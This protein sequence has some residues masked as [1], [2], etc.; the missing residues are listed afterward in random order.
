[1]AILSVIVPIFNASQFLKESLDSVLNQNVQ[2]LEV[3]CVND[4]S[5]D[6][7]LEILKGYK[8]KRIKIF[9][10]E[11]KGP[12]AT[13]NRG[14]KEA[15]GEYVAFFD[16][17]DIVTPVMYEK[18][19]DIAIKE[20]L[21]IVMCGFQYF[22]HKVVRIP[23][24]K[25]N[26]VVDPITFLSKNKKIHTTSDLCF[27]WRFIFKKSFLLNNNLQFIESIKYGED[28]VFNLRAIMKTKR[29]FL[30]PEPLYLYRVDNPNSI[31]SK[32]YKPNMES[33][34][35][36]LVLEKKR[37]IKEYKIDEFTPITKDMSEDIVK[38]YTIMLLNNLK[39]N[40]NEPNKN[41]GIRRIV[42]M[43]MIREAFKEVG[44]RNIYS[45]WKEYIFY[46]SV[47]YKCIHIIKKIFFD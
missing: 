35:E 25:S 28:M 9:S 12:S 36:Q 40:P 23:D 1:M 15:E 46:L 41:K 39:N 3:I 26:M 27:S 6:N 45:S 17:D 14:L 24:F 18:M 30:I 13:R 31:M 11:N 20:D 21:D 44:F 33:G 38:R 29:I 19:L 32:K 42:E 8:D 34:L 2:D 4:G 22:P 5:T 7:S 47:R 16:A 10:Q 43:P 37:L